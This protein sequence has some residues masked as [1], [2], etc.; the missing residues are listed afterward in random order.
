MPVPGEGQF[1]LGAHAVRGGHE[2]RL[3]HAREIGTEKTAETADIGQDTPRL[4]G[5]HKPPDTPHQGIA[6]LNIDAGGGIGTRAFTGHSS[7]LA[8]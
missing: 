1:E 3:G 5:G 7:L 8:P 2:H 6:R 4:R